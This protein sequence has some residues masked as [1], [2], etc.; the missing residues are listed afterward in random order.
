MSFRHLDVHE[1]AVRFLPLGSEIAAA[2]P[3]RHAAL[4]AQLRRASLSIPSNIAE[5]CGKTTGPDQRRIYA[6]ARGSAMDAQ[7][8]WMRAWR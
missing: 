2:L 5:G 1:L 7:R 3:Q 4:A 6:M 8:S